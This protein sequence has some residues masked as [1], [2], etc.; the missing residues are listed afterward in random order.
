MDV[1][2]F[3]LAAGGDVVGEGG[4]DFEEL[5]CCWC[6]GDW[7]GGTHWG[8]GV[9]ERRPGMGAELRRDWRGGCFPTQNIMYSTCCLQKQQYPLSSTNRPQPQEKRYRTNEVFLHPPSLHLILRRY[10]GLVLRV[11][12]TARRQNKLTS[13]N[14][15]AWR[16]TAANAGRWDLRLTYRQKGSAGASAL[17]CSTST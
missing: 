11:T 2:G 15:S 8:K 5:G 6:H 3:A 10:P 16:S 17:V 7:T 1:A 9:R 12:R 4:G 13:S 14:F